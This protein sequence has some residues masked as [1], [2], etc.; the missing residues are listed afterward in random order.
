[1]KNVPVTKEALASL[2]KGVLDQARIA[3]PTFTATTNDYIN[4]I[5]KIGDVVSFEYEVPTE[6]TWIDG[7]KMPYG[8]TIEEIIEDFPMP[9][10]N[11]PENGIVGNDVPYYPTY[12]KA[13]YSY[14][15]GAERW[16]ETKKH[17]SIQKAMRS[18][19]EANKFF[20][21]IAYKLESG[22]RLFRNDCKKALLGKFAMQALNNLK[23]ATAYTATTVITNNEIG[24][25]YKNGNEVAIA[26]KTKD[27]TSK[28]WANA[29]ADGTLVKPEFVSSMAIPT[30]TTTGEDTL[31]D[32]KLQVKKATKAKN[33]SCLSGGLIPS[34]RP[35]LLK[36]VINLSVVPTLDVKTFAGAFHED[37][38]TSGVEIEEVDSFGEEADS[39][40]IW[41]MLVD[42]RG[43]KLRNQFMETIAIPTADH[44]TQYD[45][46]A[47]DIPF[48]GTSTYLHI[49]KK[50]E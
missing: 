26:F 46:E 38:L 22:Y 31:I 21:D 41:A 3:D 34:V 20:A 48:Y 43:V 12:R 15:L 4:A 27:A 9:I 49:W 25:Y 30:D 2:I 29:I 35:N 36:L 14:S 18:E 33:H 42:I 11:V 45:K 50:P 10:A 1:M 23:N 44:I 5:N 24:K 28:T 39:K 17:D 19:S 16:R 6:L 8:S 32:F 37:K 47:R 7:E 13:A 40:G